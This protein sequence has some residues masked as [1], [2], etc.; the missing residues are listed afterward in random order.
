MNRR[1]GVARATHS[2]DGTARMCSMLSTRLLPLVAC[3]TIASCGGASDSEPPAGT[4]ISLLP[5][6]Y[7]GTFPCVNCP[8]ISTALWLR[9]DGRY[10]IRQRYLADEDDEEMIAYGL[11]RWNW[12]EA[13]R[14][15]ALAGGGPSRQFTWPDRDTLIMQAESDLEHR[16]TRDPEM[17]EFTSSVRMTGMMRVSGE[18]AWFTECLTGLEAPV[19]KGGDHRRFLHQYRRAA[20]PGKRVFVELQ[21]R[22]SWSNDGA[23]ASLTIDQFVTVKEREFCRSP[24]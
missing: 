7:T 11:G 13:D 16:L 2:T 5:G 15:V 21:G 8:G 3:F 17:P 24:G 22:F 6:V 20:A 9:P 1:V 12:V 19:G 18:G 4:P 23:P 14:A 10:F